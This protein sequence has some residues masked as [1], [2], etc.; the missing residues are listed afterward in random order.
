M[1]NIPERLSQVIKELKITQNEFAES[2]GV[3]QSALSRWISGQRPIDKTV[4][5]AIEAV[6]GVSSAW[7]SEGTGKMFDKQ[8]KDEKLPVDFK[9]IIRDLRNNQYHKEAIDIMIRLPPNEFVTVYRMLR[10]LAKKD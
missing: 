9:K 10:G 6:F 1:H 3:T 8:R 2:I 7:L 4:I 5:F